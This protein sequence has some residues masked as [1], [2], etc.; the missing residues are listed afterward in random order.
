MPAGA[1]SALD[2]ALEL[3]AADGETS[4]RIDVKNENFGSI[5]VSSAFARYHRHLVHLDLSMNK[6]VAVQGSFDCPSLRRLIMSDNLLKEI[7]PFML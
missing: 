2:Q 6:I 5:D 7:S 4:R 3:N 1:N